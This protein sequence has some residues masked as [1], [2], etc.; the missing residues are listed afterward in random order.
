M[1]LLMEMQIKIT[2]ENH[3][4][5]GVIE[6]LLLVAL[7]AIVISIIQLQYIPQV[8]EQR[9]ADHMDEVSN[10]FSTL[11]SLIDIQ[12]LTGTM[13]VDV[14]LSYVPMMEQI[15]L[16]S[17][18]MPY[19]ISAPAYG[20]LSV[21]NSGQS[22]ITMEPPD[23]LYYT[24]QRNN[25]SLSLIKYSADN[26]YFIDQTYLLEGGGI[27]L[28]QSDGSSVMRAD[29]CISIKDMGYQIVVRWY[30]PNIIGVQGKND[31]YGD[32]KCFVRTNYSGYQNFSGPVHNI[33]IKSDYLDAWNESLVK[34]FSNEIINGDV[35][36]SIT[37][38]HG[39]DVVKIISLHPESK[40]LYLS[41]M[42]VDIFCQIGPGW[43]I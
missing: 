8:M 29:S 15:T 25:F 13:G 3:A 4:V 12:A 43:V 38:Y 17:K 1:Y 22:Y 27:I 10:Q 7:V 26:S 2:K 34:I 32:G 33:I 42:V 40:P 19:F 28:S 23:Y 31:T 11:K 41:L 36:I 5:A 20:G 37:Q 9:E 16:G 21:S 6:A 30:L 39:K 14:P 18:E 24:G 35:N